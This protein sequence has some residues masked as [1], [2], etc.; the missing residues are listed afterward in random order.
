MSTIGTSGGNKTIAAITVGTSGGNKAVVT[1]YV[2]TSGGNKVFFSAL[3]ASASP[4]S[5][6]GSGGGV[7]GT[8]TSGST[9][10][11]PSGG[12]GPFTYS[13]VKTGGG[14][15]AADSSSSATTTFSA[16][17][18]AGIVRITTWVCNVTDTGTGIVAQTNTVTVTLDN[19]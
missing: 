2:G 5:V 1:G 11:T 16:G 15:T 3:A 8:V 4:S 12:I 13:W 14:T 17:L 19:T 7:P 18:G 10:A 6:N 9:T